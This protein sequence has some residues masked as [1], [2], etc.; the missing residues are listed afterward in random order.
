MTPKAEE[1]QE[2]II[3]NKTDVTI[4]E[5][6]SLVAAKL[7]IKNWEKVYTWLTKK[8]NLSENDADFI[9]YKTKEHLQ[10]LEKQSS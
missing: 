3:K 8:H 7:Y 9:F 1:K 2:A 10:N 4:N 6:I 5:W